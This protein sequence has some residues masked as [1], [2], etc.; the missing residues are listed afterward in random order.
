[1]ALL[2]CCVVAAVPEFAGPP[3]SS[4]SHAR[5]AVE[6]RETG[7]SVAYDFNE[8]PR[9]C[10][11]RRCYPEPAD[12]RSSRYLRVDVTTD[13][14]AGARIRTHLI[15]FDD[16]VERAL[17]NQH[18]TLDFEGTRTYSFDLRRYSGGDLDLIRDDD[19]AR[20]S[21][22]NFALSPGK[23][24]TGRVSFTRIALTQEPEGTIVGM[25][26]VDAAYVSD[27]ALIAAIEWPQDVPETLDGFGLHLKQ[28]ATPRFLFA[29]DGAE[30]YVATLEKRYGSHVNGRT[31]EAERILD[32]TFLFE[33]IERRLP[34]PIEW[35]QGRCEYTNILNRLQYLESLAVA[36]WASGDDAYARDGVHLLREWIRRNPPTRICTNDYGIDGNGWRSLEV[37]VRCDTILRAFYLLRETEAMAPEDAA[38]VAR[39]LAEHA[40][41]LC[42]F[43]DAYGY[44]PGNFQVVEAAGIA[45]VGIMFPEFREAPAWRDTGLHWLYEH[46]ERDVYPDGAHWEVT[47]GYHGWVAE[48]FTTV[49]RLAELNGIGIDESFRSRLRGMYEFDLR[50]V[51]PSGH[52]PMTGDCGRYSLRSR[53]ATGALL[54]DDPSFRSQAADTLPL[55]ALALFGEEAVARYDS[56]ASRTPAFT[57]MITPDSGY[58]VMRTGWGAGD[59]WFVFNLVPY[60]GGHSHPD[61]LSFDFQWGPVLLLGDS[62]RANYNHPLHQGHFRT[63]QAH[64]VCSVDGR[65]VDREASPERLEWTERDHWL[66][67]RGR[68]PI[69]DHT[70]ERGVLW[71]KPDTWIIRDLFRGEGGHSVERWFNHVPGY[72]GN[73][74]EAHERAAF[75][76]AQ[77]PGDCVVVSD[78]TRRIEE[79]WF[80]ISA[81]TRYEAQTTVVTSAAQFPATLWS[82]ITPRAQQ[83]PISALE[84]SCRK[85]HLRIGESNTNIEWTWP[86][87]SGESTVVVTPVP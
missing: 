20:V 8:N 2:L 65:F 15:L 67:A 74:P 82:V 14:G 4:W 77:D 28:R 49:L 62:G 85:M 76:V 32:R 52:S 37:G 1:M 72:P 39:S 69:G 75:G 19:L 61:Q 60:G 26:V 42:A 18:V 17:A 22:I 40:R 83:E 34:D 21:Q 45:L 64:N 71:V 66:A 35:H 47:P 29:N 73:V 57:S 79:G 55:P 6:D 46:M 31:R 9:G 36:Y 78:G 50:I 51:S 12:L 84:V 53:L 30:P 33:G 87:G 70:W 38:L 27:E 48:R 43:Q 54:F 59:A 3:G 11:V 56:M 81:A 24:A 68:V 80:G 63:P 44:R 16:G 86:E 7:V 13:D 5:C 58:G 23:R 10:W 41:Y 25:P